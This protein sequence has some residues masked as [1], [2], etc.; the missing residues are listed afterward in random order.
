[1]KAGA[2]QA[3]VR[4][5]EERRVGPSLG[6][7][8]IRRGFLSC[9]IGLAL[10]FV[11]SL[12]YYKIGG[13]FEPTMTPGK[14]ALFLLKLIL[15]ESEETWPLLIDQPEDDLDSR[16]IYDDIVPFLKK[17]KKERQIIMVSHDANL[18]IGSDSEQVIVAN[19]YGTDRENV[20]GKQFNYLTFH[21]Y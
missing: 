20:D 10:V 18:V 3:P 12:F 9:L 6:Q 2:F 4:Y 17:K 21:G 5:E 14:R 11:F 8:S 13:F 19:R 16:S 15:A 7:D 1:M